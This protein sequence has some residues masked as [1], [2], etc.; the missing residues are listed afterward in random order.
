MYYLVI[1]SAIK[2]VFAVRILL[3]D[4]DDCIARLSLQWKR[5]I[6]AARLNTDFK[7]KSY[8]FDVN[9]YHYFLYFLLLAKFYFKSHLYDTHTEQCLGFSW[10]QFVSRLVLKKQ[11]LRILKM[12]FTERHQSFS[13]WAPSIQ[14]QNKIKTLLAVFVNCWWMKGKKCNLT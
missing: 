1:P 3:I 5:T 13:F 11:P 4:G 12:C 7:S 6:S 9:Y 14:H 2:T 8:F 10:L